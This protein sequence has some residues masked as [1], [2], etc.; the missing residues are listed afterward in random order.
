MQV[1]QAMHSV[2]FYGLFMD[3]DL[4][5][6]KGFNPANPRLAQVAGYRL[7]IGDRATLEASEHACVF[8][9]VMDLDREELDLL[10]GEK[11]VA[12]YVPEQMLAIDRQGKSHAVI[13]YILPLEKVSGSNHEYARLLALTARKIGFPAGY[14][15]EIESWVRAG[16]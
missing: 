6:E 12:D 10:Y 14:V 2:F 16:A 11:S 13:S 15:D 4:L 3:G 9:S 1:E 7:R 8:G 5:R